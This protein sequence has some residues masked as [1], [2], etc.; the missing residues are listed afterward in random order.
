MFPEIRKIR[1]FLER[2]QYT[3]QGNGGSMG[4]TLERRE[5]C[6]KDLETCANVR[7]NITGS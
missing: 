7:Y 5:I 6:S 3:E 4:A 2:M 1:I